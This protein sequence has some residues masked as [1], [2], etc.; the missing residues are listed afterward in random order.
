MLKSSEKVRLCVA[1]RE[2]LDR[3]KLIRLLQD[4]KTGET[5]VN[6]DKFKFGRSVYICK[7]ENCITKFLKNKRY[8]DKFKKEELIEQINNQW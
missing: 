2:K 3:E 5:F 1:C 4:H 8:K 7:N 6:P